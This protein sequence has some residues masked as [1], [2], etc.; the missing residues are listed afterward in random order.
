MNLTCLNENTTLHEQNQHASS[1]H[2]LKFNFAQ[3]INSLLL[4]LFAFIL[5]VSCTKENSIPSSQ[6][7]DLAGK[8]N[9]VS[10][11]GGIAG[12]TYTPKS[13]KKTIKIEYDTNFI[14]RYYENDTLKSESGYQLIKGRSIYSQDSTMIITMGN[15]SIRQSY[16]IRSRDTLI[17]MDECFDCFNHLYVRI[18]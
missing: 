13:L 18:K 16:Q 9:W 11:S 17:L 2:P 15:S 4:F 5:L 6:S 8:W 3:M 7:S 1:L 10:S 12:I 14:Y